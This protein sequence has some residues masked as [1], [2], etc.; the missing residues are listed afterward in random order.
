LS[1]DGVQEAVP[2]ALRPASKCKPW[3]ELGGLVWTSN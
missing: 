3:N 2:K 1:K